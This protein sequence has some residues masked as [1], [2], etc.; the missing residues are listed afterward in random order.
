MHTFITRTLAI[1]GTIAIL[2]VACTDN[3]PSEPSRRLPSNVI[4]TL[5]FA[6]DTL[7]LQAGH[8]PDAVQLSRA[9]TNGV[10][11]STQGL[12]RITWTMPDTSLFA[13]KKNHYGTPDVISSTL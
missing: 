5:S 13:V 6:P 2:T 12:S 4:A 9:R 11:L 1:T 10:P 8:D 7:N 3:G